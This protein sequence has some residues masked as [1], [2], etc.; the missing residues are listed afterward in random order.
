MISKSAED[1]PVRLQAD[2]RPT[3]YIET[4]LEKLDNWS[5]AKAEGEY[6]V[7]IFCS[8]VRLLAAGPGI[9]FATLSL[10]E[11]CWA[12]CKGECKVGG[13]GSCSAVILEG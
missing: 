11:R 6:L 3:K 2:T 8:P 4:K 13:R 9:V 10:T 12:F 7:L 1:R 5:E